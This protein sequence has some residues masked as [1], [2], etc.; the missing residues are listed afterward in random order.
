MYESMYKILLLDQRLPGPIGVVGNWLVGSLV[1]NAV[2]SETSLRI[3]L[4]FCIKLG[5]Y[6]GRKDTELD[7]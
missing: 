5:D 4:I 3:F 1:G 7:F 2:F 6:K